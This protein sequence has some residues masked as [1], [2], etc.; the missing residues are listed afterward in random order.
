MGHS[1]RTSTTL[2]HTYIFT[3]LYTE[4][5][6][7]AGLCGLLMRLYIERRC[8]HRTSIH[9]G[10]HIKGSTLRHLLMGRK[11]RKGDETLLNRGGCQQRKLLEETLQT[12]NTWVPLPNS[13]LA[14]YLAW[15]SIVIYIEIRIGI[16]FYQSL[17]AES[18]R[19][20]ATP[21]DQKTQRSSRRPLNRTYK[22]QCGRVTSI[23]RPLHRI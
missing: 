15:G 23:R 8:E 10:F 14:E 19:K 22:G 9:N 17:C 12:D 21:F 3:L 6:N 1:T 7:S 16:R 5:E 20:V 11:K 13:A 2:R 4:S 18:T